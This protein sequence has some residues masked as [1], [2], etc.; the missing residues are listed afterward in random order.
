M[1][2][3]YMKNGRLRGDASMPAKARNYHEDYTT[4]TTPIVYNGYAERPRRRP[5]TR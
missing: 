3:W 5:P 2:D 1:R 4:I